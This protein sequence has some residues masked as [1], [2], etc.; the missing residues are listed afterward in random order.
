SLER[1]EEVQIPATSFAGLTLADATGDGKPD[2]LWGSTEESLVRVLP[3]NADGTFGT[4]LGLPVEGQTVDILVVDVDQDND[5]DIVAAG[6]WGDLYYFSGQGNGSYAASEYI[7]VH[8]LNE[9]AQLELLD[10]DG[11]G[12]DELIEQQTSGLVG[13]ERHILSFEL[14][15]ATLGAPEIVFTGYFYGAGLFIDVNQD[16]WMDAVFWV[17]NGI[18]VMRG[19]GSGQIESYPLISLPDQRVA[20][21]NP[22]LREHLAAG[23]LDGNGEI[24]LVSLRGSL[25]FNEGGGLFSEASLPELSDLGQLATDVAIADSGRDNHPDIVISVSSSPEYAV[26]VLRVFRMGANRVI[27]G[28]TDYPSGPSPLLLDLALINDDELPDAV[29]LNTPLGETPSVSVMLG[30]EA[31]GFGSPQT[32]ELPNNANLISPRAMEVGDVTGNGRRDILVLSW[33]V[34]GDRGTYA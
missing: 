12:E 25:L 31:G 27:D 23:D 5:S 14:G 17:S 28:Y 22:A 16:N 1:L 26:N 8:D 20:W 11:D 29:T 6:Q 4:A 34:S 10:I 24:D 15:E 19:I 21:Q 18:T 30:L 2:L 33:A 13:H 9:S 32:M 3:G 7:V